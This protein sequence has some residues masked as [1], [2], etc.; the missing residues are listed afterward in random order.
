MLR[1]LPTCRQRKKGKKKK[2]NCP[3]KCRLGR[4]EILYDWLRQIN[5]TLYML[6]LIR[7]ISLLLSHFVIT[8][9][10]RKRQIQT[11]RRPVYLVYWSVCQTKQYSVKV[12]RLCRTSKVFFFFISKGYVYLAVFF[13]AAR[14]C[15]ASD[16]ENEFPSLNKPKFLS[17]IEEFSSPYIFYS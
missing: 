16:H 13:Y 10:E 8:E 11:V 9:Q 4:D 1:I 14:W 15:Q 12:V 3:R 6:A 17:I 7:N 2:K 5:L